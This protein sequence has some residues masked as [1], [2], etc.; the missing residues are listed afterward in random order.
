MANIVPAV[1][2][3]QGN[4][5]PDALVADHHDELSSNVVHRLW[6]SFE[7]LVCGNGYQIKRIVVA[8]GRK[9]SL[10]YHHHRSEHWTVVCGEA[11]VTLGEDII[12]MQPDDSIY[13]PLG[14]VHRIENRG[15]NDVVIV[16]VQC[17]DYLGEDDIV[18][19]E[20]DFGRA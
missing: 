10:Q 8:P 15:E 14:S 17:G 7:S 20:D 4:S 2:A 16:E 3:A 13:I 9:L 6:G 5:A 19:I 11:H 1:C 12:P 18:R